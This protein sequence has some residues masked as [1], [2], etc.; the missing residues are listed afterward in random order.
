MVQSMTCF[1]F[2]G[3]RCFDSLIGLPAAAATDTR[4]WHR[5]RRRR[6]RRPRL[7]PS[8]SSEHDPYGRGQ[9]VSSDFTRRQDRRHRTGSRRE[10]KVDADDAKDFCF[11]KGAFTQS[12]FALNAQIHAKL[13][14]Y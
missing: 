6:P 14:C 4:P 2:L 13:L 3:M 9:G 1:G 5:D 12:L 10:R 8:Q 11:K 7:T